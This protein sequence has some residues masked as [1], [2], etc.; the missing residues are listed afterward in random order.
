MANCLLLYFTDFAVLF[1]T[2]YT[3][4]SKLASEENMGKPSEV[5]FKC[6]LEKVSFIIVP[7]I[8]FLVI[9]K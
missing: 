4:V 1:Y 9:N 3:S 8:H 5:E 2:T 6:C 7:I